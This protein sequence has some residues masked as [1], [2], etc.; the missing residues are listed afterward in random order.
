MLCISGNMERLRTNFT[1]RYLHV[2]IY[3][4]WSYCWNNL[5]TCRL[6]I[7]VYDLFCV[8]NDQRLPTKRRQNDQIIRIK[9]S[10]ITVLDWM[11]EW[12]A[13]FQVKCLTVEMSHKQTPRSCF[14]SL[15]RRC[16]NVSSHCALGFIW[17]KI[18]HF[19]SFLLL[20]WTPRAIRGF[21]S[22]PDSSRDGKRS[23]NVGLPL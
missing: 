16:G 9:R 23:Q 6:K 17:K 20:F 5:Q 4:V 18:N 7:H 2:C 15:N 21:A 12:A 10:G 8:I 13:L 19:C 11:N 3:R 22:S 14:S 1:S